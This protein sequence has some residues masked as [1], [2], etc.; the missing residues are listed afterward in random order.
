MRLTADYH[1]HT[2]YSDARCTVDEQVARAKELGL[3]EIAVTDHG[4][5]HLAFG[6]RRREREAYIAEI[7]AAEK[8]HG[9]R[10]LVGIEGNILGRNGT[11]DL[12]EED[13]SRFDLYLAGIHAFSRH[14]TFRDF[15]NGVRGFFAYR[16]GKRPPARLVEDTTR[17]FINV[18]KKNPID[19]LTHV[20]F[21]CFCD[22]VEVA[23]CCRDYGTY[24]EISG[25]KPHFT[26]EELFRVAETGVRFVINSDAHSPDRVGDVAIAEEQILRVGVP[27]D[28]IDNIDGRKPQLRLAAYKKSL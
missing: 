23:K 4:F 22:C 6:L 12:T 27:L 18:V 2:N 11:S 7:K 9:I 10:V 26:D 17:S 20:N 24:I 1:I 3:E 25:K 14:E 15:R 16:S 19:V 28:K 8:K 21:Q 5:T 13:L